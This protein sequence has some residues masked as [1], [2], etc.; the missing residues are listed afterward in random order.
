MRLRPA[1][2]GASSPSRPHHARPARAVAYLAAYEAVAAPDGGALDSNPFELLAAHGAT[3]VADAG[4][5]SIVA[6]RRNG[7][8]ST[9]AAVPTTSV[10]VPF[11]VEMQ[12]VPTATA[13]G[14]DGALS[15]GQPTGFPLPV[16]G[17]TVWRIGLD[18]SLYV[19][20]LASTGL[21]TR[22][23]RWAR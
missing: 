14:P 11:P 21:T 12:A 8:V 15:V 13:I 10:T 9:V 18:G 22:A 17:S 5:N 2:V 3:D 23:C 20:E 19:V 7:R 4:R 1:A 16:G 6:I